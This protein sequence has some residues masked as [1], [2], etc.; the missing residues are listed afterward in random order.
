MAAP[1]YPYRA[2][3]DVILGGEV[4]FRAGDLVPEST[5]KDHGLSKDVVEKVQVP[6]GA[7]HPAVPGAGADDLEPNGE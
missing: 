1:A 5:V 6:E 2:R 4:A 7:Q 3:V